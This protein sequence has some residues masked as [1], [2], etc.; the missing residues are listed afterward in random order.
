MDNLNRDLNDYIKKKMDDLEAEVKMIK[1]YVNRHMDGTCSRKNDNLI[2]LEA[3]L[4]NQQK[5]NDY[6]L[7]RIYVIVA[8][9]FFMFVMIIMK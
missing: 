6:L 2:F 5:I 8:V 4:V 9:L 3:E 1:S 7:A